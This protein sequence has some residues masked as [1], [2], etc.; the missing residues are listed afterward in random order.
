MSERARAE[1]KQWRYAWTLRF[2][3]ESRLA[4]F[5]LHAR[6]VNFSFS[7][8]QRVHQSRADTTSALSTPTSRL[9]RVVR[10]VRVA[11]TPRPRSQAPPPLHDFTISGIRLSSPSPCRRILTPCSFPC[12]EI[13]LRL[14][15]TDL[16]ISGLAC[17]R[18]RP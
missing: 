16:H 4:S 6:R 15:E 9:H 17:A 5:D 14:C 3:A 1:A 11:Q 7:R 8:T 13:E 12:K 18:H 2:G 10:S